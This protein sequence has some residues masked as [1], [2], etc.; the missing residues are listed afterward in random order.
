MNKWQEVIEKENETA[1]KEDEID[2][3]KKARQSL[4]NAAAELEKNEKEYR[5]SL[6]DSVQWYITHLKERTVYSD[7]VMKMINDSKNALEQCKNLKEY[8]QLKSD[9]D[10]AI[11]YAQKLP[12]YVE[13]PTVIQPEDKDYE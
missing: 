13:K 5:D 8:D 4:E 3:E 2:I 10:E 6:V 12:V 9:L 7:K 1:Q 11:S